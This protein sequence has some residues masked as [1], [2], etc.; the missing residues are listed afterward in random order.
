MVGKSWSKLSR[1]APN[2]V[3]TWRAAQLLTKR[4]RPQLRKFR[5]VS[6]APREIVLPIVIHR[7]VQAKNL[8]PPNQT[9]LETRADRCKLKRPPEWYSMTT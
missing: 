2:N 8:P 7:V 3:S 1:A 6:F 5:R 9:T 4:G